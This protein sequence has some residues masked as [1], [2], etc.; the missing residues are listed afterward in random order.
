MIIQNAL[1]KYSVVACESVHIFRPHACYIVGMQG[2]STQFTYVRTSVGW[3]TK[4]FSDISL[5]LLERALSIFF[6]SYLW[7]K[8]ST[9]YCM[10]SSIARP[11]MS[12][13]GVASDAQ[14][15]VEAV[16]APALSSQ[17]HF[18]YVLL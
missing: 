14:G 7:Q 16:S 3:F 11:R 8:Y 6:Y 4:H 5:L 13:G 15:P 2:C 18:R 1:V 12:G 10:H 9:T 17:S